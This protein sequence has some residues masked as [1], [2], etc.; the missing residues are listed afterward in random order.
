M[1]IY[2]AR[3]R[4][5]VER[6]KWLESP[7]HTMVR[8]MGGGGAI[9]AGV[10]IGDASRRGS[11][12]HREIVGRFRRRKSTRVIRLYDQFAPG[13]LTYAF[14]SMRGS[15]PPPGHEFGQV[16]TYHREH[17][18]GL[19]A[20]AQLGAAAGSFFTEFQVAARA[21]MT[22]TLRRAISDHLAANPRCQIPG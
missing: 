11:E 10:K 7:A 16:A 2:T 22:A 17:L 9:I 8:R 18:L 15:A 12:G 14:G 20:I 1:Q 6:R 19:F 5:A 4:S 3:T 21:S 13:A